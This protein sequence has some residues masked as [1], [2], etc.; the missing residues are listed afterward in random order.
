MIVKEDKI[1]TLI[2][3]KSFDGEVLDEHGDF[4]RIASEGTNI[5]L[6]PAECFA[7]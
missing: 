3:A 6:D 2:K 4:G 1:N 5:L 7:L